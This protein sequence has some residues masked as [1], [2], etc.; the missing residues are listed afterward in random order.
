M[1]VK[2]VVSKRGRVMVSADLLRVVLVA[3]RRGRAVKKMNRAF[4]GWFA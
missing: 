3:G 4:D 2:S 1:Y